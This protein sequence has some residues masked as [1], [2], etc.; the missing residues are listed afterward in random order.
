LACADIIGVRRAVRV[1]GATEAEWQAALQPEL[2][3]VAISL[4]ALIEDGGAGRLRV[5]DAWR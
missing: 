1:D 5:A 4:P 3:P 2:Q